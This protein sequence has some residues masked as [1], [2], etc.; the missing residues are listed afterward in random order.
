MT[1]IDRLA[2]WL[3]DQRDLDGSIQR[4][5]DIQ[6]ASEHLKNRFPG[7]TF[8]KAM[9]CQG[10]TGR[11]VAPDKKAMQPTPEA[12]LPAPGDI[13]WALAGNAKKN[14]K[15]DGITYRLY[16][17]GDV[18]II[19]PDTKELTAKVVEQVA[20]KLKTVTAHLDVL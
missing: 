4:V 12:E 11:A 8:C 5:F 13:Q 15:V 2:H 1:L 17:I 3:D 9:E 19:I 16:V 18:K 7:D 20:S 14:I 6:H 10:R